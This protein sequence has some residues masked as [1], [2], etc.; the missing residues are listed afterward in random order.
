MDTLNE[1]RAFTKGKEYIAE[2]VDSSKYCYK[3]TSDNSPS[4]YL[5][6]SDVNEYF[7]EI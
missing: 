6:V 2:I 4:H 1:D 7:I 5:D 3:F